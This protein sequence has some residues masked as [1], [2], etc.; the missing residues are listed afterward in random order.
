MDTAETALLPLV[1]RRKITVAEYHE[2]GEAGI[3]HEDDRVELIDGELVAM[4]PIGSEHNGTVGWLTRSL[5]RA[6]GDRAF[7]LVQGSIRLDEQTEPQPDF[8]VLR[9]RADSYRKALAMPA[10]VLLLIEIADSSLRFD[11]SVKRPLYARAGIPEYWIVNL[12]DGQVEIF[13][14]PQN[15]DYASVAPA[16]RGEVIE[17]A[18]LPGV[19]I[20]V[21][22]L[23]G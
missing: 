4:A 14:D 8:S 16:G 23:L 13:R 19:A 15:A 20:P 11:R 5:V 6:V 12:T 9:P 17:P 10:D 1:A 21:S 3:L 2:M 22:D 7:V 18:L